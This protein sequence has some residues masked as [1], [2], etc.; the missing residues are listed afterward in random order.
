MLRGESQPQEAD[1]HAHRA[2]LPRT[3]KTDLAAEEDDIGKVRPRAAQRGLAAS[4]ILF[5]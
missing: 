3:E 1:G 4:V 5:S 2:A